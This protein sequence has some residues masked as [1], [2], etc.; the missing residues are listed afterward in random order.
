MKKTDFDLIIIGGGATGA[1]IAL[2]ASLRG[3]SVA[4][5]E[6]NDFGEGTSSRST[7][8]V[9]GGVRYLEAAVK[10]LDRSQ[11]ALVKE[12]LKERKLFLNNA[13]H[14]AHPIELITPIYRWWEVPY[15]YAG[16]FLYDLISG[17]ASLGRS[18]L[19]SRSKA[20][21]LNPAINATGLKAAVSYYDGAFNDSRM[22][23]ALLQSAQAQGAKVYNHHQIT[24]LHKE[25]GVL[26]GITVLDKLANHE[27]QYHAS[28][29]LNATGPFVDTIRRLDDP[30][31]A[32]IIQASSG[33]HII[34]DSKFLPS[35]KGIMIPQTSDGRVLFVLPYQGR[36]MIGTSD[37]P[38]ALT[39]H[40]EVTDTEI[41]YLLENVNHYFGIKVTPEDILGRFSGLRPLLVQEDTT[42]TAMLVREHIETFSD[43]GLLT[44]AGGKWTSY[45][46]MAESAVDMVL[47]RLGRTLHTHP[48]QTEHYPLVGSEHLEQAT[49]LPKRLVERYGDQAS[50]ILKIAT[51]ENAEERLHKDLEISKAELLYTIRYEYVRKPLDFIVRRVNLGLIDQEDAQKLL[52]PVL[53]VLKEEFDL[54]DSTLLT[55]EEESLAL[56]RKAI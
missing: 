1:G 9:H 44:I 48:C 31:C 38:S 24:S 15:V 51:E 18:R 28:V 30:T 41:G 35:S 32:P 12:G 2:D 14:L 45:R 10:K 55:L 47:Q 7:K 27:K 13:K 17:K 11:Y 6:Q 56:L 50:K 19:L 46:S 36:C 3:L 29:I 25:A 8:L 26:S 42:D 37:N 22:V 40:P 54:T 16:L 23:I 21:S 20:L 33:I 5:F 34:V 52:P 39:E 53:L 4:L 43:A 49:S